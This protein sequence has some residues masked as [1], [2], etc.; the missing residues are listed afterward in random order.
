MRTAQALTER[1]NS[2]QFDFEA[3][4][5]AGVVPPQWPADPIQAAMDCDRQIHVDVQI[6]VCRE[7]DL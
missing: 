3:L 7:T 1:I 6:L 5:R 2:C 4:H